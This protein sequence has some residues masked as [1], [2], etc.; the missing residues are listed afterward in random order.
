MSKT[1]TVAILYICTGRYSI[2]WQNFYKACEENFLLDCQKHYFVFTD[3][4]AILEIKDERIHPVLQ[5]I[6]EWPFPTLHRFDYFLRI[7]SEL[8]Q[9]DYVMFWNSNILVKEKIYADEFLPRAEKNE[10]L[11]VVQHPGF[12]NKKPDEITYDRNPKC[13]AYIPY[14]SGSFYFWGGANGGEASEYIKM[15]EILADRIRK[16]YENG[17]IALWHDESHLNKYMYEYKEPFRILPPDYG[18][19]EDWDL[20]FE[21]KVLILDKAKHGGHNFLRNIDE[22]ASAS[23]NDQKPSF[24]RRVYRRLKKMFGK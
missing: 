16:D 19:A 21:Q 4:A 3:D 10:K 13:L 12:Y 9:F 20:P 1:K 2:F 17:V 18:Y 7:K 22:K 23:K 11:F 24:A 8:L 14:G 6:E 15:C 5:E